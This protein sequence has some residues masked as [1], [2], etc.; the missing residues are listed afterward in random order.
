MKGPQPRSRWYD[1]FLY[2]MGADPIAAGAFLKTVSSYVSDHESVI[3]I[4]CGVGTLVVGL[5]G[6]CSRVT[7]VELSPRM[8]AY[9]GRR[10]KARG[11]RNAQIILASA[12]DL[13]SHV[14][15]RYDFAVMTQFLH[16]L[17]DEVRDGVMSEALK[18]A[19]GF[20]IA[21]FIAPF[22]DTLKGRLIRLLEMCAGRE[23]NR[24]FRKWLEGGGL[25]GFLERYGLK[26]VQER[27]FSNG[28]GKI[29]KA[30]PR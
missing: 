9:A 17:S 20:I 29:V 13:S 4:G 3:D 24:N 27:R 23:H 21:D 2:R 10:L 11:I 14:P 30:V 25:D 22:P 18:V 28:A 15:G 7:G 12:T 8:A 1:G 26:V 5:A 19:G 16:E 6:K